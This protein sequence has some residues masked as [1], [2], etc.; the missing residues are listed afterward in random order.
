[1]RGIVCRAGGRR[2]GNPRSRAFAGLTQLCFRH[3]MRN[4]KLKN[5]R[6]RIAASYYSPDVFSFLIFHSFV[7]NGTAM[8]NTALHPDKQ[9]SKATLKLRLLK[10]LKCTTKFEKLAW[11]AG[12]KLVAGVDE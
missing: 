12:A 11:V 9:V 6:N 4:E 2:T 8:P 3:T 5:G 1:M 7:V 10:R